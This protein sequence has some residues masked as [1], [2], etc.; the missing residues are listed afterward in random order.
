MFFGLCLAGIFLSGCKLSAQDIQRRLLETEG[1]M[2]LSSELIIS[3]KR[4]IA[5]ACKVSLKTNL[6]P[7]GFDAYRKKVCRGHSVV[8]QS[9]PICTWGFLVSVLAGVWT[10]S[11]LEYYHLIDSCSCF[12]VVFCIRFQPTAEDR[13]TYKG[14]KGSVSSL[15]DVDQFMMQVCLLSAPASLIS[16]FTTISVGTQHK[17]RLQKVVYWIE[18]VSN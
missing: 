8:R 17:L 18:K 14:F 2:V 10:L 9:T 7:A 5:L 12:C 1:D 3:L 13:E 16:T 6:G 15:Q 4:W 11:N